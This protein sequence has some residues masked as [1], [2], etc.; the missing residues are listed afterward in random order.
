MY[1][2]DNGSA[3][4]KKKEKGDVKVSAV[5]LRYTNGKQELQ[6]INL[7]RSNLLFNTS[8]VLI[9]TCTDTAVITSARFN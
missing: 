3:E 5:V 6:Q 4:K 8:P 7:M 9:T 1:S 2:S